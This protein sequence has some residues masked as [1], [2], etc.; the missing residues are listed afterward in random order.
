MKNNKK[1]RKIKVPAAKFGLGNNQQSIYPDYAANFMNQAQYDN[2]SRQL[3]LD[4]MNRNPLGAQNYANNLANTIE[5]KALAELG[6]NKGAGK[7]GLNLGKTLGSVGTG[8]LNNADGALDLLTNPFTTSTATTGKEAAMQSIANVGK[9]AAMGMQIAGPWGALAGAAIGAIG[10]KGEEAEMTSFT[11]YNEGTLGTGL[12]G[13]FTNGRLR[14]ERERIKM[15]A[16]KNR[17]AVRG[18]EYLA[19]EYEMEHGDLDTNSFAF[20][21]NSNSLAYVD[22]GE[23]INTP[24]GNM[25]A[26]PE[27]GKPVDSNLVSLPEGSRILS[28]TLKIPGTGKTFAEEGKRIM[29]RK[30]NISEIILNYQK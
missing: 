17:D 12:I 16:N 14:R 23:L 22:D 3:K 19:N 11:D 2:A 5:G 25:T 24:D 18:T 27:E 7:S 4:I 9:G 15:N 30:K 20:G 1:K 8:L 21:G 6:G 10:N 29:K 26:I 28:N 13:A